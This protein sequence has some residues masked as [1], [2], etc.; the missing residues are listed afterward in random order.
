RNCG[1]WA[2]TIAGGHHNAVIG[3]DISATGAGGVSLNGGDRKTLERGD[4]RADNNCIHHIAEF[5]RT[6]NTGVNVN[7]VGNTASHNLIHDCYHQAILMGGNDNV[8]EFN[9]IHHTNLGS[10][11]TGGLYMSSRDYTQRGNVIRYNVFHHIGGFGKANSWQPV[12]DGKVRFEYPH[13]TWGIYLDAPEVGVTVYGNVLYSVPVCG[14]FNHEGRDNT[15]ENNIVVDAPGFQLSSGNYPDLDEQSYSYVKRLRADGT[16]AAYREHY[17]E[18]DTY[19]DDPASRHTVAGTKFLHNILYYTAEGGQWLREQN[20]GP[21]QGGQLVYNW[22]GAK[23]DLERFVS[24]GNCVWGPPGLDLKFRLDARPEPGRLLTW[25]EWRQTGQDA[26]SL[27]ADPLFIDPEHHDYRLRA[28]SPALKLGFKPTPFDQIGP[29]Q[30]ELRASWPVVEAP[31]AAR[32][33]DFVTVRYFQVPGHE[34]VTATELQARGG[35]PRL[36]RKLAAQEPV[37]IVCFAGGSHAQGG[38]FNAFVDKLRQAHPGVEI[39]GVLA[40]IDGGARGSAFSLYRFRHEALG[41]HPDLVIL[42]FGS[43][44]SESNATLVERVAEGLVRQAWEADPALDLL[45][46]HAFRAGYETSYA[47]GVCPAAVSAWER[48]GERYGIPAINFGCRLAAEVR[49]GAWVVRA[50]PEE[51]KQPGAKPVFTTDGVYTSPA[52]WAH[53]AE[54]AAEGVARLLAARPAGVD[55]AAALARPLRADHL[56]RARQ[57]PISR[58]MLEGA[59]EEQPP[60]AFAQHFERIWFTRTPGAKLAFRFRGTAASLFDLMGPDTGRVK[61][62]VDGQDRGQRQ[63]V[64]RW[65]YYQRLSGLELASGLPDAEHTVTVELLPDVPDRAEPIAEAKRLGRYDAK[66]FEG[67]ALRIGWIRVVGEALP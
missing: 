24:D 27:V 23:A 65:C 59:W 18:L 2:A 38:W 10:E 31:G 44:D 55:R 48:V 15:W 56:Q 60:A 21:W 63:Q 49:A 19:T 6:Y 14:L 17:P 62:T 46:V 34:P 3:C 8:A 42:D 9:V 16:Y 67:V 11:D 33:G 58:A 39:R 54:V 5:Q 50:T 61:V 51:A 41:Q 12:V 22:R 36:S 32:L 45:L 28:D 25:D 53:E 29:Y 40:A 30:D 20:R 43:D 7:G 13:F 1:G 26:H 57:I 37:A 47:D 4:N 64:D 35:L 66:A 52:A